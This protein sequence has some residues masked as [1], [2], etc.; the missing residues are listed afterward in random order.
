MRK[1]N[2]Q[3]I[4]AAGG[5]VYRDRPDGARQV[6]VIHRP[7]Y[8]DWTLPKGKV[9]SGETIHKAAEREVEEETGFKVKRQGG[10]VIAQNSYHDRKGRTKIVYYYFMTPIG[11]EFR[12]NDEVDEVR[13]LTLDEALALLTHDRDREMLAAVLPNAPPL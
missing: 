12:P 1:Q 8:N 5:I 11:G 6:A 9:D 2:S 4:K 10:S 13:W 3:V 7:R